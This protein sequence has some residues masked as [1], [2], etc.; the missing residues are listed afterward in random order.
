MSILKRTT[1]IVLCLIIALSVVI[2]PASASAASVEKKSMVQYKQINLSF[3]KEEADNYEC[4]VENNDKGYI[5][6]DAKNEGNYY[7][8]MVNSEKVTP[9]TNK[10]VKS[11]NLPLQPIKR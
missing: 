5:S 2:A 11:M 6:V 9:K 7:W 1:G 3:V 10:P 4:V 8:L